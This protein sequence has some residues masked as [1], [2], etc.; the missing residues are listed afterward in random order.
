MPLSYE[1]DIDQHAIITSGWDHVSLGDAFAYYD[2]L[3][4]MPTDLK[5]CVD[6]LDLN[7]VTQFAVS[8]KGAVQL[9]AAYEQVLK[10]GL[11]GAVVYV[12]SSE[13]QESLEMLLFTFSEVCG[14]LPE[15]YRISPEPVPAAKLHE[16]LAAGTDGRV[17]SKVA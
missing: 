6:Y 12:T 10:R 5:G 2:A 4:H 1:Y 13:V 14:R 9:A 11:R 17:T 15:G 16:F 7:E 3:A 8:E